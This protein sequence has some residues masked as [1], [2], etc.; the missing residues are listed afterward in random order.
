M[1]KI[2]N[3]AEILTFDTI[4]YEINAN[5]KI[6]ALSEIKLYV[7]DRPVTIKGCSTLNVETNEGI[8]ELVD[9]IDLT[10]K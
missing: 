6:S 8:I 2:L 3:S 5:H 10:K 1:T 7:G 9:K 4:R